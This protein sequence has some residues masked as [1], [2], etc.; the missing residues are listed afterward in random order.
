MRGVPISG[1]TR[2]GRHL[3]GVRPCRRARWPCRQGGVDY[4]GRAAAPSASF[5][6]DVASD[7]YRMDIRYSRL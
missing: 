7:D 2:A 3:T 5:Y 4:T 1:R 6:S